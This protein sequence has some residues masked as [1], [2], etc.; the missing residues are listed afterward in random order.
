MDSKAKKSSRRAF[1]PEEIKML[2]HSPQYTETASETKQFRRAWQFWLPLIAL[3]TGARIE[4]ICQLHLTDVRLIDDVWCFDINN[5]GDK[6]LK[7]EA[8][9]RRVPVHPFL[10]ETGLLNR[11]EAL[12]NCGESHLFS[13]ASLSHGGTYASATA[14]KWFTRYRRDCGVGADAGE[15]SS[16]TFHSFRHTFITWMKL[17]DI[18]RR[19][20][21]EVVGHEAGEFAD[22]TGDYEGQYPTSTLLRDVIAP[23]DFHRTI[24]LEHLKNNRWIQIP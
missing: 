12:R 6:E 17:N 7:T 3:Y 18:D 20:V 9:K 19:K 16:T 11:I 24:N 23:I 13:R 1:T 5:E 15:I 2:F 21:K 14:S 10:I 8:S 4:E 22:V